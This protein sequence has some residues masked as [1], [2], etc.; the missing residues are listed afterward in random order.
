MS[1]RQSE[2]LVFDTNH[3]PEPSSVFPL[4]PF[5]QEE[6][7]ILSELVII[8]DVESRAKESLLRKLSE[9]EF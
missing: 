1:E 7:R 6:V 2:Y 9:L 8:S 4:G 3:E 5:N